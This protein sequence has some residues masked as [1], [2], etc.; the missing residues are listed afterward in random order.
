MN[1]RLW[2]IA[3]IFINII[4]RRIPGLKYLFPGSKRRKLGYAGVAATTDN[5]IIPKFI[6]L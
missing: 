6:F 1:H 3:Y 4:Q 5:K 2:S